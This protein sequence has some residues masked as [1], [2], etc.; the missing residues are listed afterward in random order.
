MVSRQS[1]MIAS[2]QGIIAYGLIVDVACR[3]PRGNQL[4]RWQRRAGGA[5]QPVRLLQHVGVFGLLARKEAEGH[6]QRA[7]RQPYQHN[8][9][10]RALVGGVE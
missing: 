2:L 3:F 6:K 5:D 7:K 9:A 4:I 8:P 1:D 10:V